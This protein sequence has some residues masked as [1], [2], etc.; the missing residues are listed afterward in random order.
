MAFWSKRSQTNGG[1]AFNLSQDIYAAFE[2]VS[3]TLVCGATNKVRVPAFHAN[4]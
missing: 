3:L 1:Q 2:N 4:V